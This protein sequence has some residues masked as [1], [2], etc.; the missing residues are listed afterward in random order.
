[1]EKDLKRIEFD[2][3]LEI[4]SNEASSEA[5]QI[6]IKNIVPA[7]ALETVKMLMSETFDAYNLSL[8]LEFPSF[9]GIFPIESVLSRACGG[10]ILQNI[11]FLHLLS[12]LRTIR[13]LKEWRES[14]IETKT[15]LD[16]KFNRIS[17]NKYLEKKI[18]S[19][20][21]SESEISDSAS[22]ELFE[23]RSKIKNLNQKIRKDLERM[24]NSSKYKKYLTDSIVTDRLGRFAVQVK[25]EYKGA[26]KGLVQGIS[27]SGATLFVE[28]ISVVEGNNRINELRNEEKKEIEKIL[29]K[30]SREVENFAENILI[31][32]KETVELDVIFAKASLAVKMRASV[33]EINRCG[34]IS[35]KKA[36]HPLIASEKVQPIDIDLGE[37]FDTLVITGPNTGGKTV[38]IKTVGLMCAMAM[39]G[40]MIP[41][42]DGSCVSVFNEILADIG[43]EQNIE[44]SVSTFSSHMINMVSIMKRASD[45]TLVLLD[46]IGAGTDPEEGAALSIAI[47]EKLRARKTKTIA[48]THY[49]ELKEYAIFNKD[50]EC[51]SCEF[52][53]KQLK[54][55]YKILM[56]GIGNS[57]AFLISEKLGL[58]SNIIESAKDILGKERL[59]LNEILTELEK[60]RIEAQQNSIKTEELYNEAKRIREEAGKREEKLKKEY[61]K[62]LDDA[63][64][65]AKMILNRAKDET[66]ELLKSLN[67]K[68]KQKSEICPND[69]HNIKNKIRELENLVDPIE[70][71]GDRGNSDEKFYKGERVFVSDFGKEGIVC[72]D[73][74]DKGNVLVSIGKVKTQILKSKLKK[75]EKRD[76]KKANKFLSGFKRSNGKSASMELDIRGKTVLEAYQELELFLD[77][78]L[79]SGLNQVTVIHGKGSGNLRKGVHDILSKNRRIKG[80]RLGEFHEGG[81]GVT[82]ISLK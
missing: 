12:T 80:F 39:S 65:K 29:F 69:R 37:K 19:A 46:E 2:K 13:L 15:S 38:A 70:P 8:K 67:E 4:L 51:A 7:R 34:I 25:S 16:E 27:A 30:L 22:H 60:K 14:L 61:E 73:E 58:D 74:D 17:A 3:V 35:L 21:V 40:M 48:T 50:V 56:G 9:S 32:Y 75:S 44:Q 59:K 72:S 26:I 24:V 77:G 52:D 82:V 64:F 6:A 66:E 5:A 55:T 1:M 10:A 23:I 36:R 31:S 45:K 11:E 63:R 43:D 42:Q 54:P 41:A 47:L 79:I 62:I 20:I 78:A 57:N 33:P 28:P 68:Q 81:D 53:L 18:N 76:K 49:K 71:K